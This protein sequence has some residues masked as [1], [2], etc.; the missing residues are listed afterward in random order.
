MNPPN[1]ILHIIHPTKHTITTLPLTRNLR[2]MFRL[3][4]RTIFLTREP[5]LGSL[6][7]TI[8]T[9]K[10]MFLV[11]IKMFAQVAGPCEDGFGCAAGVAAAP[12]AG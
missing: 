1:M 2:I 3:M 5:A 8:K 7:A 10:E 6:R 9:A 12:G 4:P 11:S